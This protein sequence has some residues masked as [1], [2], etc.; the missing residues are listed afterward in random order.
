MAKIQQRVLILA[1]T[2]M[3]VPDGWGEPRFYPDDPISAVPPP[4]R[5]E[6]AKGR[7]ISHEGA[8]AFSEPRATA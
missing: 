1:A 5:V 7:K 2:A 3:F 4:M 8:P 6:K